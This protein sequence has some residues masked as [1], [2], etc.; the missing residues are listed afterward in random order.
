MEWLQMTSLPI[1]ERELR[2]AAR[3]HGTY[4]LRLFIA[5]AAIGVGVFFYALNVQMSLI[6]LGPKIFQGLSALALIYCLASGRRLTADCLSIEKREGTLGLL[7]L[8]DLQGYD[9]VLG[10]LAATSLN[11]FFCLMAIF[12]VIAVPMMMGGVG[13]GE[14]WRMTLVL[15]NTF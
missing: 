2:V 13:R 5:L 4:S 6:T 10:K 7:F 11:A 3:R 8:T 14:F 12:P 9:V 15:V 1:V